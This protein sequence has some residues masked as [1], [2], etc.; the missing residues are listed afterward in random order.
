MS[1]LSTPKLVL[2]RI[3]DDQ[4][5]LG[6]IFVG[7]VLATTLVAAVPIYLNSLE[8]LALNIEIDQLGRFQSKVL[9][10]AFNVPLT[11]AQISHT[12]QAF[13]ETVDEHLSEVYA[14][15]ERYV[16][17]LELYV[18]I[19]AI[20][21][22][23]PGVQNG[24]AARTYLRNISH[25][26]DHVEV[27]TGR[28]PRRQPSSDGGEPVLEAVLGQSAAAEFGLLVGDVMRV[29]IDPSDP[30]SISVPIVGIVEA[31]DPDADYWLPSAAL[32]FDPEVPDPEDEGDGIYNPLIP[33]VPLFVD[34]SALVDTVGTTY[35][36]TLSTTIWIMSVDQEMMKSWTPKQLWVR[37]GDFE[38]QFT[39]RMPGSSEITS[40]ILRMM[41]R[42]EVRSFFSRV[43]LLLLQAVMV[44]TVLFFLVMMVSYLVKSREADAAL[45]RTRGVGLT[46]LFQIYAIEGLVMTVVAM[47]LSPFLAMIGVAVAGKLPFFEGMTNGDFLPLVI[48]RTPFVVAAI[49][50][51]ACFTLY[52]VPAVIGT[53]GGLLVHKLRSSRPPAIP[54]VH[55]YYFDVGFLAIGGLIFW[56]LYNRG[57]ILAGGLF[58]NVEVNEAFLLAP[59]LFLLVVALLF[60]RLF[61]ILLRYVTGESPILV[62]VLVG[63]AVVP[64][65]VGIPYREI[66]DG[67]GGDWIS[68]VAILVLIVAAYWFTHRSVLVRYRLVGYLVQ[69]TLV[70]WF[71]TEEPIRTAGE[72]TAATAVL[73]AI[74]PAQLLH[75]FF[76]GATRLTPA[77][78]SIG[79]W[80]ISRNPLQYS[81]LILLLVMVTGV[82][83]LATTVGGTLKR[84]QID[85][86][87]YDAGADIRV[88]LSASTVLGQVPKDVLLD[89]YS[90]I[91]GVTAVSPAYREGQAA[92]TDNI[93]MLAIDSR[94]FPFLVWYR[95]DFSDQPLTTI[96]RALN[97]HTAPERTVVPE[98]AASIGVWVKLLEPIDQ[99]WMR[100]VLQE[101]DGDLTTLSMG[102]IWDAPPQRQ[103]GTDSEI[104]IIPKEQPELEWTLLRQPLSGSLLHPVSLVSF[105][106]FEARVGTL[107]PGTLFIDEVHVTMNGSGEEAVIE[108]FEG[109]FRWIPI[110]TSG[111]VPDQIFSSNGD[112]HDGE[113]SAMFRFGQEGERGVRGI[114]LSP[115]GGPL[116]VVVSAGFQ[117]NFGT[118]IGDLIVTRVGGR[119]VPAVIRDVVDHFPTMS[120]GQSGFILADLDAMLGH[121]NIID[122][123]TAISPNEVFLSTSPAAHDA[124]SEGVN[125]MSLSPGTIYDRFSRVEAARLDPL[126][127]A[128]WTSMVIVAIGII[129]ATTTVGYVTYLLAFLDENKGEM[130][131]LRSLGLSG[132]QILGLLGFEHLTMVVIGAG[133]GTWA[134][135]QMSH[136]MVSSIV[137]VSPDEV[138]P[139]Y[140][141]ITDWGLMLPTYLALLGIILGTFYILQRS[142]RHIDLQKIARVE[143][144]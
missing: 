130:G 129:L 106:F 127:T 66:R 89:R 27:V 105:Q 94:E 78:V 125:S 110:V 132:R 18:G 3:R 37:F 122:P 140:A 90:R 123:I 92:R 83:I 117:R 32:Y 85:R 30:D 77:W 36:G 133:L 79:F 135:F 108:D 43:P 48:D 65:G 8:R 7:I 102:Q 73:V 56:E 50:G 21:L 126:T 82:G 40:G 91:P 139:P 6:S 49:T 120:P 128:G 98:E 75:V 34:L 60:L 101:G 2:R 104:V 84:N 62:H 9:G 45:L 54:F 71:L 12:E 143:G 68:S 80:R 93:E 100:I 17:G 131:F 55:R 95:E 44:A 121:T 15:H 72:L 136:I 74:V 112:S 115:T 118:E 29:T 5:L 23:P 119:A 51:V 113:R 57:Q 86:A 31:A 114:Y 81:W 47:I 103:Q 24:S 141:T 58:K 16:T 19:P 26:Q 39:Q 142:V 76:N 46:Q 25:F 96:M 63:L 38:T 97:T 41:A 33:P 10:F 138:L 87:Q 35:T 107:T 61:P 116:P 28:L 4:M 70:F 144:F 52:T 20:P 1:P 42:F 14:G 67:I 13:T 69:I 109:V 124:V 53:R 137:I 134:G 22:P 11:E 88:S 59:V 99:L 64:L 111:F